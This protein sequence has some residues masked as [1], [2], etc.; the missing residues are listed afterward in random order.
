M[1]VLWISDINHLKSRI[2]TRNIGVGTHYGN[3]FS[4]PWRVNTSYPMKVVT[5]IDALSRN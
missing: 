5:I 1:R 3:V 4:I 2:S